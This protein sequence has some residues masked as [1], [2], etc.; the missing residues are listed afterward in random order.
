MGQVGLLLSL[1]IISLIAAIAQT[2]GLVG[3]IA[4]EALAPYKWQLL[5]G[6]TIAIVLSEGLSYLLARRMATRTIGSADA[7]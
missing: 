3:F 2:A 4:F 5:I 6:G 1:K 7:R